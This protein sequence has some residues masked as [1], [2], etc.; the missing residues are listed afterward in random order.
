[1]TQT[2]GPPR[3]ANAPPDR[4]GPGGTTFEHRRVVAPF[5][6]AAC[7][8]PSDMANAYPLAVVQPYTLVNDNSFTKPL[9]LTGRVGHRDGRWPQC[10]PRRIPVNARPARRREPGPAARHVKTFA[11]ALMAP[12]GEALCDAGYRERTPERTNARNGCLQHP[13]DPGIDDAEQFPDVQQVGDA[14]QGE[15]DDHE[16]A[17]F[18]GDAAYGVLNVR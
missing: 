13:S 3:R 5:E 2:A 7:Q 4:V 8:D 1:M 12:E 10:G 18:A 11:E 14:A 9:R 17:D 15:E 6:L 16:Y